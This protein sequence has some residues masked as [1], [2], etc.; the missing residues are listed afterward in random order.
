MRTVFQIYLLNT[1][2]FITKRTVMPAIFFFVLARGLKYNLK[3]TVRTVTGNWKSALAKL[4]FN[5]LGKGDMEFDRKLDIARKEM[6]SLFQ[7]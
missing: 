3:W 6:P 4:L 7:K 5:F 2:S 1:L